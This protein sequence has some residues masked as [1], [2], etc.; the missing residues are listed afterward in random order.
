MAG[1]PVVTSSCQASL[2]LRWE[3]WDAWRWDAW[4]KVTCYLMEGW[5]HKPRTPGSQAYPFATFSPSPTIF[6]LVMM[7]VGDPP[8]PVS[9][10]VTVAAFPALLPCCFRTDR[11]DF[12]RIW[13][14]PGDL[15][16]WPCGKTTIESGWL[17]RADG[18]KRDFFFFF[19]EKREELSCF[20]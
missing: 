12:C 9:S 15:W 19:K 11:R 20:F 3:S 13:R 4:S 8:S 2:M 1:R 5:S 17:S 14:T 16:C 6:W 10:Y 18:L 7:A